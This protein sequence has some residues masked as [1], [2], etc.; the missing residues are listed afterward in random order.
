MTE[1]V[2][3]QGRIRDIRVYRNSFLGMGALVCSVF[4][5]FGSWPLYGAAGAMPQ[6]T[7]WL[8]FFVIGCRSFSAKPNRVLL[9]GVLSILVWV[10]V[11]L[12]NRL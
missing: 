6:F 4:L 3:P 7:L 8:V 9:V 5:I 11:V 12:I 1:E 2:E 10:A